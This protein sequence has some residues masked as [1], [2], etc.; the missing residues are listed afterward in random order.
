MTTA[1]YRQLTDLLVNA[2]DRLCEGRVVFVT[3]GGYDLA[4]LTECL[5]VVLDACR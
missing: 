5:D 3:E 2:A 1:G 4:A